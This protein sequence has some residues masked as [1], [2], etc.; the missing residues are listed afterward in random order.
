[1]YREEVGYEKVEV[2][3]HKFLT[4]HYMTETQLHASAALPPAESTLGTHVPW[5]VSNANMMNIVTNI[6]FIR[7][8]AN[9]ITP[10]DCA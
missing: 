4:R 7:I 9:E 6:T 3:G 10:Y 1:M 8:H 2:K 5:K